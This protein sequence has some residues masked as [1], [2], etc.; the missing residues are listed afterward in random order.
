M[1]NGLVICFAL[2][3]HQISTESTWSRYVSMEYDVLVCVAMLMICETCHSLLREGFFLLSA[4]NPQRW[5]LFLEGLYI[6]WTSRIYELHY[7]I[8]F[9]FFFYLSSSN[10][11]GLIACG[12]EDGAV[13]CFDMR[14]KSSVARINAVAHGGDAA[15]VIILT[16]MLHILI[17]LLNI[18]SIFLIIFLFLCIG[19]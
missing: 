19:W 13:E 15:A 4:L 6:I 10:L 16:Y 3:H 18:T 8:L 9:N 2:L 1:I 17:R 5:M 14:M 7:Y 11:H 12:G